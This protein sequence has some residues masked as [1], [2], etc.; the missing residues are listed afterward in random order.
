MTSR[1]AAYARYSS[2]RQSPASIADQLRNCREY[3]EQRDWHFQ[4][5]HIY[6]DHALSGAGAD[7]PGFVKLME[8]ARQIP[9][10]RSPLAAAYLAHRLYIPKLP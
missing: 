2:D 7:R 9:P 4:D 10:Q 3:A 6:T 8:A 1:T 5:E